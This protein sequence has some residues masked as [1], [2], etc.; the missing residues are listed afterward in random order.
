MSSDGSSTS[1]RGI[2]RTNEA[3][4]K[5]YALAVQHLEEVQRGRSSTTDPEGP[6]AEALFNANVALAEAK[7]SV[8]M[9]GILVF[10][11]LQAAAVS[12]AGAA[13]AQR[14]DK[15]QEALRD[16]ERQQRR[17]EEELQY[18]IKCNTPLD[19]PPAAVEESQRR[20]IVLQN[21]TCRSASDSTSQAKGLDGPGTLPCFLFDPTPDGRVVAA[22]LPE[23]AWNDAAA[24][25]PALLACDTARLDM[26]DTMEKV[27]DG[28]ALKEVTVPH[29]VGKLLEQYHA[30]SEVV[31]NKT[32]MLHCGVASVLAD[33]AS[34]P[35]EMGGIQ[36]QAGRRGFI[37]CRVRE[38]KRSSRSC[39]D[40]LPQAFLVAAN[41]C[42]HLVRLGLRPV[43]AIVP[44]DVVAGNMIQFGA[45]FLADGTLPLP[46]VLSDPLNLGSRAGARGA[47]GYLRKTQQHLEHL[48]ALLRAATPQAEPCPAV[49]FLDVP[50]SVFVK[51]HCVNIDN[52]K[53]NATALGNAVG[54]AL[55]QEK[56]RTWVV[57]MYHVFGQ[58]YEFGP[59]TKVC[60]PLGHAVNVL[61]PGEP[62]TPSWGMFFPNLS[63]SSNL[64]AGGAYKLH[65]PATK[66]QLAR[67]AAALGVFISE[68]HAAQV[69]HGDLYPSNILWREVAPTP[70]ASGPAA[71]DAG[72]THVT[73]DGGY[74]M[75]LKIV[76]WDTAFFLRRKGTTWDVPPH[77]LE[78][79]K[80]KPKW[81][82]RFHTSRDPRDLDIF[83]AD[84][85]QFVLEEYE[86]TS[87][88]SPVVALWEQVADATS[89][90]ES[91]AKFKML[92]QMYV[93]KNS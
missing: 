8:A 17:R 24:P 68:I 5:M 38:Y 92:Q 37:P 55:E 71:D 70:S 86:Q 23:P 4:A 79:W 47:D 72:P 39:L 88:E 75:E 13:S 93:T 63:L 1:T 87:Q 41:L 69:V 2:A 36:M 58:L 57:N 9:K 84:V 14:L 46:L 89:V 78:L 10:H 73:Q 43:D 76:D 83:M 53:S 30:K 91:N 42:A 74:L 15:A 80:D 28:G 45:C 54:S 90:R 11:A 18:V 40:V 44:V 32:A 20:R 52:C 22:L 33:S 50:D 65:P 19:Q 48:F 60:F 21:G 31:L 51:Q 56:L 29:V 7:V 67:F 26:T 3:A 61:L 12:G 81:L 6:S 59:R 64:N 62:D 85:L 66:S 16:A 25:V 49:A 27:T 35:D 77:L 82:G 34:Q